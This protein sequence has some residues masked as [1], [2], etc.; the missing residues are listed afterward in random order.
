MITKEL[1][2]LDIVHRRNK[3][4][5]RISNKR[6]QSN[7]PDVF[8]VVINKQTVRRLEVIQA[9]QMQVGS[10]QTSLKAIVNKILEDYCN[11]NELLINRLKAELD[12]GAD[13]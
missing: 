3:D 1:H 4:A 9:Y 12:G 6:R 13:L 10:R 2:E 7:E 5:N 11:N 8:T